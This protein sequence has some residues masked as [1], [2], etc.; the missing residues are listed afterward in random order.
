MEVTKK[1]GNMKYKL[2]LFFLEVTEEGK[3]RNGEKLPAT[4]L[5]VYW[6][7]GEH[8]CPLNKAFNILSI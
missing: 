5:G 6:V 3:E 8:K 2:F 1:R 7:L 4:V